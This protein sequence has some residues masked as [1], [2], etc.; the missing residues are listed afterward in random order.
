MR[1]RLFAAACASALSFHAT[2]IWAADPDI[3]APLHFGTWGV[4][5]SARDPKVAPGDDFFQYAQGTWY[6]AAVIPPDQDST[7]ASG[8]TVIN[9]TQDQLRAIIE[10]AAKDPKTPT[11]AQ[12]GGLY[13]AF[14]DEAKIEAL[15]AAPLQPDLAQ[16]AAIPDKAAFT[17]FMGQTQGRFGISMFGVGVGP[18]PRHPQVNILY[19]GQAGLGLPDRDYY[20]T[21][22]FK[23][24]KAAYLAYAQRAL[25]MIGY[26]DPAGNAQAILDLETRIAQASW[27]ADE[28]RDIVKETNPM[29]VA[30]LQAY[31]P[32][33]DWNAF[34]IAAGAPGQAEVIANEKS[35]LQQIA[36]I[37]ADTPLP[38]LKAWEA[39]QV[40]DGAAP[41]LSKRFVDSQFTFNKVLSGNEIIRP[42]WKRGVSLV[43]GS[44]GE[45]LGREY[46]AAYF[47]PSSKAQMEDL[48]A[49]LKAA[50]AARIQNAPWMADSSKAEALKKLAKMNVQVGYPDK[51]R[52]YSKLVIDPNDLYGDVERSGLFEWDYQL[53]DLDKP[54][55]HEKW[56]MTPQTVN[57]YN[58]FEEN[59]IVFPAGILQAPDFDPTADPAV[60]YGGIGAIIGHEITHGFDDQGRKIDSTGALRDWWTLQDAARFEAQATKYGA[61]FDTYEG[62][63]GVHING[64]L[65]MGE[66][67][68]DL[69][70]LLIAL[71]AYHASLHGQ[72]APMIDGL[73][74]DQ[75]FFLAYAQAWQ[76]KDRVESLKEQMASDPHSPS[77]FRVLGTTR[78]VDAWYAAFDVQ[79]GQ[80]YYLAPA[81]RVRIW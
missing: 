15:D 78:N 57:A 4:D 14:M 72:P 79:P 44:L 69:G 25:S 43:D 37:Y 33:L 1:L 27:A 47:P 22:S 50:L 80:K 34:L 31:A 20:L 30:E 12:I 48:V 7:G 65:T 17:V 51:W 35:A 3:A 67:I 60:N 54:V 73:T 26:P 45:A 36:K 32:G 66:N 55:D 74:G 76:E 6:A 81:D 77:I 63:P 52:N 62:V 8:Y 59:K 75:R 71:D 68:A 53:S 39:F 64:Q 21:D 29:T 18:D 28:R 23:A 11:A 49:N 5:L 19:L 58:G 70:G 10:A 38:V 9:H 42:R 56:G 13:S 61:Q 2:T 16:V 46:V 41:Y 24:Q 40:T